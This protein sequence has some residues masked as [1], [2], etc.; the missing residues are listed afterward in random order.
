MPHTE[1][2]A[3]DRDA[4]QPRTFAVCDE[5]RTLNTKWAFRVTIPAPTWCRPTAPGS[6]PTRYKSS[7]NAT[8]F[9]NSRTLF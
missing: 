6:L 7:P 8:N 1:L 2:S 5:S 4:M 3:A 9:Q